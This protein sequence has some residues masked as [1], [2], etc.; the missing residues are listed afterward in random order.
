MALILVDEDCVAE[1]P[2]GVM[3]FGLYSCSAL[4][5]RMDD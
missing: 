5:C 1:A 4:L 3:P 2:D